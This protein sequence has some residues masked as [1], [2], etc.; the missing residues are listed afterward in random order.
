MALSQRAGWMASN[1]AESFGL[2][3]YEAVEV[4]RLPQYTQTFEDFFNGKGP[5]SIF[6]YYQVPY[7]INESG[8]IQYF[9]SPKEFFVTNGEKIKLNEM[10]CYFFRN[11]EP[12]KKINEAIPN[13]N[14]VLF[15]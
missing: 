13:D 10:G 14:Q 12:G 5:E 7:K 8:D 1:V 15:G 11:L 6:I 9:N 2:Q 3:E 4:F